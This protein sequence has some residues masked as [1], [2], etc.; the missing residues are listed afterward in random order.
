VCNKA[1]EAR[2]CSN[3]K[4]SADAVCHDL[5]VTD[6]L[7]MGTTAGNEVALQVIHVRICRQQTAQ[8]IRESYFGAGQMRRSWDVL[9][10][11][12]CVTMMVLGS[13]QDVFAFQ[14]NCE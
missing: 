10:I 7:I 1:G 11:H 13:R 14:A 4:T 3:T 2:S 12:Q 6:S 5:K 9:P 8:S